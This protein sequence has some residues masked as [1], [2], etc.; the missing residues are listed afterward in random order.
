M[1]SLCDT[2]MEQD[3]IF[4]K[5]ID[6]LTDETLLDSMVLDYQI[7]KLSQLWNSE[8]YIWNRWIRS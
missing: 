7:F 8:E 1:N 6:E 4:N 5:Q 3:D 2:D